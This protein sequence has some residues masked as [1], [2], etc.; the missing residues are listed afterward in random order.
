M[1]TFKEHKTVADRSASDRSRHKRKIEEAI[2]DGIHHIV[3]DESII[4]QDGTKKFKIPVRGIKEYRF[5]FSDNEQN[6]RSASAPGKNIKKGQQIGSAQK[7]QEGKAGDKASNERG[8]EFYEVEITLEE[9][10]YYLFNDLELP[11]LEKKTIK[12]IVGKKYKRHGYRKKG[13]RPR[14]DKKKTAIQRIK[15]KKASS[16]EQE[17]DEES[18]P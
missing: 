13:I 6:P 18:F 9:L 8:E 4:G 11:D 2:K 16:R 15:R 12:N 3:S 5:I 7:E 1:S 17:V 10:A 14:L